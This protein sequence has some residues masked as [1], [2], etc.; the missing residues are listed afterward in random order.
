M[1][2]EF[3]TTK[4]GSLLRGVRDALRDS[5]RVLICVAFAAEAGVRLLQKELEVLRQRDRPVGLMATTTFGTTTPA[6]LGL[7]QKLGL[8]VR[9]YDPSRGTFHPKVYLGIGK[10]GAVKAVIGS[11][12]LT[13]GLATNVEAGMYLQGTLRDEPLKNAWE[14]AEDRWGDPV[15][16]LWTTKTVGVVTAEVIDPELYAELERAVEADPLFWTLGSS[17]R[18]NL[19]HTVMP[20][21]VLV[22]TDKSKAEGGLPQPIPAWMLNVAWEYVRG[23]DVLTN[24]YLLNELRVHRSS[25][26]CAILARIPGIEPFVSGRRIGI[27]ASNRRSH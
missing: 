7:A 18:R 6:A 19:V 5:E 16:E 25:V 4:D 2:A 17:P 14:W 9:T 13:G 11:A 26:V 8:D 3:V 10:R 24:H 23:H 15:V 20:T 27:R 12:N 21:H 1:R 22:E